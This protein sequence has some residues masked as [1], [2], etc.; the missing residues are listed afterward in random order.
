VETVDLDRWDRQVKSR[1]NAR[2]ISLGLIL[3]ISLVLGTIPASASATVVTEP[4]PD[5]LAPTVTLDQPTSRSNNTTP[6]FSGTAS[7]ATPVTVDVYHGESA[8]GTPTVTLKSQVTGERWASADV[9]PPLTD[10]AYTAVATQPGSFGSP[11]GVSNSVRFEIDTQPP[12]V[13]LKAPP[14]P[15][16]DTTP[17]FAGTASEARQVTV[18]LFEGTKPEGNIVATATASASAGSWTSGPVTPALPSGIHTFTAI[19]IQASAI[20]NSAGKSAPVTFVVDTEP[21]TLTL[22]ALPSPSNDTTPSFSGTASEPTQVTVE[23]F[24]GT[25]PEGNVVATATASASA[26]SWTSDPVTPALPSGIHTFT[27]IATQAS[28]IGNSA[29]KSAPVTFVVDTEPP[30]VTLKAL[31]SPSGDANPTFSGT[32]SDHTPITVEIYRG[33]HA[34]G[35]AVASTTAEADSGDWVSAK[36]SSP[37]EWG[38]YTAVATQPSS[39]GNPSG[40]SSP[41]AFA[42]EPIAPT[43]AT[44][45]ASAVT[46]TSAALYASVDPEGAGVNACRFEYG[47]TLA[48]GESI[49]CGFVSEISAFPPSDTAAVPVFARIYGLS[50][51]TTYHFRIVA[52][53][54]GGTAVGGDETFTTVAPWVFNEGASAGG[55]ASVQSGPPSAHGIAASGLLAFIARQLTPR[56][57]TARIDALLTTGVFS[58]LFRAPGPGKAVV[59]WY[60]QPPGARRGGRPAPPPVLVAAGA[61]RFHAARTAALKIQLTS[62]GRRLLSGSGRIRLTAR[63]VFTPVG[64]ASVRTNATFE[65]SR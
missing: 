53:G 10:G 60:Y 50:P 64:A 52:V 65:L 1:S 28:A 62:A 25:K 13:T 12:T 54:E 38:E 32:A 6:S 58:A 26:G 7:E 27:A 5:E 22:K 3:A 35:A 44:E 43:V 49:E 63:C 20:G 19:A 34:E 57:R 47:T 18:E 29:G 15:S 9:S 21:P 40:A 24:E 37:L 41:M 45:V 56:G 39:I 36:A 2:R 14:S 33:D 55:K 17:S 61:L 4:F 11:T 30:T 46:R 51:S 23:L 8:E 31:P 48:Y 42:V 59:V 16:N